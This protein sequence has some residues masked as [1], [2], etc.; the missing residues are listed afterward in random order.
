MSYKTKARALIAL[1]AALVIALALGAINA[2]GRRAA[3]I[4]K[5]SFGSGLERIAGIRVSAPGL[6]FDLQKRGESWTLSDAGGRPPRGQ[7]AH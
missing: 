5:L 6:T 1:N 4:I 7:R 2:P 3:S